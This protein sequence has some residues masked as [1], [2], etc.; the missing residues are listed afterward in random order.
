LAEGKRGCERNT[1]Q[2]RQRYG[3]KR[4]S[5]KQTKLCYYIGWWKKSF[6][7]LAGF[8]QKDVFLGWTANGYLAIF[9]EATQKGDRVCIVAAE[10]PIVMKPSGTGYEYI[11]EC[12][13]HGM[14]DGEAADERNGTGPPWDRITL[15]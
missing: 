11:G 15:V 14:M 4:Y 3:S 5:R 6:H 9:P 1:S 12:Y 13:V 8:S 2:A 7:D 10:A